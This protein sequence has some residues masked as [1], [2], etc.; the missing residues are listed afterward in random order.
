MPN[1]IS[2]PAIRID[3]DTIGIVPN[4]AEFIPGKGETNVRTAS[5]GGNSIEAVHSV[6]AESK[7]GNFKVDIYPTAA[8]ISLV[9]T[10]G[11][12][13]GIIEI[14]AIDSV[15]DTR[16]A[17]LTLQNASL[18]NDPEIPLTADGVISLEFKGTPITLG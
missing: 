18:C 5:A 17:S 7:I 3:G 1:T 15:A 13:V 2:V 9:Q 4:S 11:N 8:N 10:L 6:N 12:R 16:A 14:G